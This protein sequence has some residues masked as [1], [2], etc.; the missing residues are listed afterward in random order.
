M[1]KPAKKDKKMSHQRVLELQD[2]LEAVLEPF[3]KELEQLE[4]ISKVEDFEP[5]KT[6]I[7]KLGLILNEVKTYFKEVRDALEDIKGIPPAKELAQIVIGTSTEA[8]S[9]LKETQHHL[10]EYCSALTSKRRIP[11]GPEGLH[12]ADFSAKETIRRS[13]HILKTMSQ[14]SDELPENL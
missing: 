4:K 7:E 13:R 2:R 10:D 8:L 9:A 1:N 11:K 5:F 6:A 14:H 3:E 12:Y